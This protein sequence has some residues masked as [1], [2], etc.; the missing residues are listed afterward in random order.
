MENY[1]Y[2]QRFQPQPNKSYVLQEIQ[3]Q[4]KKTG[5]GFWVFYGMNKLKISSEAIGPLVLI[6]LTLPITDLIDLH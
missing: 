4:Y 3:A 6:R 1:K 5:V 2:L